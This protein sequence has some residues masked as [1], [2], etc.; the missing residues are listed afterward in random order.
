[1]SNVNT[2]GILGRDRY[3]G[4][5]PPARHGDWKCKRGI[6]GLCGMEMAAAIVKRHQQGPCLEKG[7]RAPGKYICETC[8][9]SFNNRRDALKR[10]R[11][12]AQKDGACPKPRSTPSTPSKP[13]PASSPTRPPGSGRGSQLNIPVGDH[14][15]SHQGGPSPGWSDGQALSYRRASDIPYPVTHHG[16]RDDY[17]PHTPPTQYWNDS[18][19]QYHPTWSPSTTMILSNNNNHGAAPAPTATQLLPISMHNNPGFG[20]QFQYEVVDSSPPGINLQW[21]VTQPP[22]YTT[23]YDPGLTTPQL[24]PG[25]DYF[26]SY[27]SPETLDH[28]Y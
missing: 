17:Q 23:P 28:S 21:Q 15:T 6:C 11:D 16:P 10:H 2:R 19:A 20:N 18:V 24:Y 12:K 3:D 27:Q 14:R 7:A 9:V 4:A 26:D 22:P 1:M 25:I 13:Y 5:S 8:G